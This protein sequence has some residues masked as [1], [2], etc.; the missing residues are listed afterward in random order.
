MI[1]LFQMAIPFPDIHPEIFSL[2]PFTLFGMEL[3]PFALRWYALA[4]I[5]GLYMGWRYLVFLSKRPALWGRDKAPYAEV[6][7]DDFIV[8]VTLGVI[9]GGR[10]G[11]I[12]FYRPDLIADNPLEI[13]AV[14]NGGMSFH[15]G[16]IGVMLA[17]WLTAKFRKIPLLSL[18]DG[19]AAA[20]PIGLFFGR[21]ANFV[22]G[23]LWGRPTKAPWGVVFPM[24]GPEPRH[25]SQIYECLLEGV[26]L[27]GVLFVATHKFKTLSKPGLNVGIFLVGYALARL[28]LENVREPDRHMPHF[29]LGLTMG[30]MLSIPM[31]IGGAFFIWNALKK[32]PPPSGAPA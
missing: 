2:G 25:P 31:F 11:Y 16:L 23:E 10:L 26:V 18:G 20:A 27:F 32:S 3:G 9:F 29:P 5:A 21:I 19:S 1:D 13:F 15:G 17:A 6:D 22:N 8:A 24:A 12:L 4:Y 28:A 14:W 7:A 30:M